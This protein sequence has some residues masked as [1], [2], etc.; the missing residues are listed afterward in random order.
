MIVHTW[1]IAIKDQVNADI[2]GA[3]AEREL[4]EELGDPKYTDPG[5]IFDIMAITVIRQN[6][7]PEP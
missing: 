1:K 2:Q 6:L 5:A 7:Q 3:Y 4:Y